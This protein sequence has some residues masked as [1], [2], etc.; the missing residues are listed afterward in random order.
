MCYV[1]A[2]EETNGTEMRGKDSPGSNSH[3]LYRP[4]AIC[5]AE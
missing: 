2:T 1:N 4:P 3:S 5:C